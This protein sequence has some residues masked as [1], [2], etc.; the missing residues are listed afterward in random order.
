MSALY[1]AA[2]PDPS[3]GDLL[4][5]RD[6]VVTFAACRRD[7]GQFL[8]QTTPAAESLL[9]WLGLEGRQGEPGGVSYL[10][11]SRSAPDGVEVRRLADGAPLRQ[12]S[13]DALRGEGMVAEAVFAALIRSSYGPEGLD[14][15]P[16]SSELSFYFED[17]LLLQGQAR[18][19]TEYLQAC[20][21][22][23]MEEL[24]PAELVTKALASLPWEV[25]ARLE[26]SAQHFAEQLHGV[27]FLL[28]SEL[29]NLKPLALLLEALLTRKDCPPGLGELL[30][31]VGSKPSRE[32]WESAWNALAESPRKELAEALCPGFGE[33]A[34]SLLFTAGPELLAWRAG[35][36]REAVS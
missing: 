6:A 16:T 26:P 7:K 29:D 17:G 9:G 12:Y 35:H 20:Q 3:E 23:F 34:S 4:A 30:A 24:T 5:F 14:Y 27:A 10:D 36:P 32:S 21:R 8:W 2:L 33:L 13:L 18:W 19:D 22:F 1:F 11:A 15:F 31:G 25:G 28:A